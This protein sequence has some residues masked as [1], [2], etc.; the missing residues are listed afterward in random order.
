MLQTVVGFQL[1]YVM[2]YV[3]QIAPALNLKFGWD[4]KKE[5][6]L[7]ESII[8][9]CVTITLMIGASVAG[10]LVRKSRRQVLLWS[11]Y[12]GI[13][14]VAITIYQR[15]WSIVLGRLIY[16]F[17][18]GFIAISMPRVMEE[19]IPNRWVGLFGGLYC[20]SFAMA[21]LIA[22]TLAVALPP[23]SDPAIADSPMVVVIFALPIPFYIAQLVLQLYIKNDPPRFLMNKGDKEGALIEIERVYD[24][25]ETTAENV[26][27]YLQTVSTKV[28]S[29]VTLREAYMS[30]TYRKGSFMAV[31][32]MISHQLS[33]M[34][35]ILFYSNTILG[36]IPGTS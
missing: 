12:I 7:N 28:T 4:T 35:C 6:D 5:Q 17:S 26:Y 13:V 36:E 27:L 18:V 33:G 20:L 14:G 34:G 10:Q 16:G 22:Y 25:S 32:V 19:T 8:G 23:D 2:C 11:A 30:R 9:S 1:G 3:N 24:L 21:T 31:L 29:K 15:F